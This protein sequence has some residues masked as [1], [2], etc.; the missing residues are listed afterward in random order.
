MV[1]RERVCGRMQFGCFRWYREPRGY[2]TEYRP[3]PRCLS[4][5]STAVGQQCCHCCPERGGSQQHLPGAHRGIIPVPNIALVSC[6]CGLMYVQ[7]AVYTAAVIYCSVWP[8]LFMSA[9]ACVC[10]V[11]QQDVHTYLVCSTQYTA[12]WLLVGESLNPLHKVRD[13]AD[14]NAAN[15]VQWFFLTRMLHGSRCYLCQ[16]R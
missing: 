7:Q 16:P 11:V 12:V 5:K 9:L 2:H 15:E 4:F 14:Q 10:C 6:L 1:E 8:V 3:K 13:L